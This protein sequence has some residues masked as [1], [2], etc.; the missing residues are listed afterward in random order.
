M[1]GAGTGDDQAVD[2][3]RMLDP[4]SV[5]VVRSPLSAASHELF[6]RLAHEGSTLRVCTGRRR[7]LLP[8]QALHRTWSEGFGRY[9]R[10]AP[11]GEMEAASA[12]LLDAARAFS[13][14]GGEAVLW[15]HLHNADPHSA[16]A[17][18][19]VVEVDSSRRPAWVLGTSL[20]D[21][22]TIDATDAADVVELLDIPESCLGDL[23][24]L[25]A[26]LEVL[27]VQHLAAGGALA[28]LVEVLDSAASVLAHA[29][30]VL[31]GERICCSGEQPPAWL[32]EVALSRLGR[33]RVDEL[34]LAVAD[35]IGEQDPLSAAELLVE[36]GGILSGPFRDQIRQLLVQALSER[37]IGDALAMMQALEQGAE[38]REA[39]ELA[40][41]R[42]RVA[43]WLGPASPTS[44]PTGGL[45]ALEK[46]ASA[47]HAAN[48][49]A[50]L[51]WTAGDLERAKAHFERA[52]ADA[53]SSLEAPVEEIELLAAL[54][55]PA[56]PRLAGTLSSLFETGLTDPVRVG[57]AI[58]RF[59][60]AVC[61]DDAS[62]AREVVAGL[63]RRATV[64]T[65]MLATILRCWSAIFEGRYIAA[66]QMLARFNT[67]T[68]LL[69]HWQHQPGFTAITRTFAVTGT[70]LDNCARLLD[71]HRTPPECTRS[72]P[73]LGQILVWSAWLR[74][75]TRLERV[76]L[77]QQILPTA[78]SYLDL[79]P[80]AAA[81]FVDELHDA[82]VPEAECSARYDVAERQSTPW[83]VA[84]KVLR[85]SAGRGSVDTGEL[86]RA[87]DTF[88]RLGAP[89]EAD[90]LRRQLR[91]FRPEDRAGSYAKSSGHG[92]GSLTARQVEIAKLAAR[93]CTNREIAARLG[94]SPNT[95]RNH[96][97][98]AFAQLGIN[99]RGELTMALDGLR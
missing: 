92:Y 36:T 89:V 16:Q 41:M 35:A 59:A 76:R 71:A 19:A 93:G 27:A 74:A 29:E 48:T 83:R 45:V 11:G 96:L 72:Y 66:E 65:V 44:D 50:W 60:L 70:D 90:L 38:P 61:G 40:L 26:A 99:S 88:V 24:E 17:L 33:R 55:D 56:E 47:F 95:V 31:E 67:P 58:V 87:L 46:D 42:I 4:S 80:F 79:F 53:P 8:G 30:A 82:G 22:D 32:A 5:T 6:D 10:L 57:P 7:C 3:G 13:R 62:A 68:G 37:R 91:R 54:G 49:E 9:G 81:A 15:C 73:P 63:E 43:N 18:A 21:R 98:A 85:E 84:R 1:D 34:R 86:L 64:E 94:I 12:S 14:Q 39:A 75:A 69:E 77:M 2:L 20:T 97:A 78:L 25:P 52:A 51:S 28:L 23:S